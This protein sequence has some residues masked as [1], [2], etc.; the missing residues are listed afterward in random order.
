MTN[1]N[2]KLQK[3]IEDFNYRCGKNQST[4]AVESKLSNKLALLA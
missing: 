2:E 3:I 1:K 4:N